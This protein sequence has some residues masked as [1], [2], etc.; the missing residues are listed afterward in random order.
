MAIDFTAELELAHHQ[1]AELADTCNTPGFKTVQK[2]FDAEIN[3]FFMALMNLPTGSPAVAEGHRVAKTAAQLW[4][5]AA[6][7][8]NQEIK[9]YGVEL[10]AEKPEAPVDPIEGS[11]DLGPRASTRES[12]EEETS[13]DY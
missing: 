11:I 3:K 10:R 5:G 8:I 7:R 4:E 9:Q 1:R 6:Q 2:I 13:L 12:L